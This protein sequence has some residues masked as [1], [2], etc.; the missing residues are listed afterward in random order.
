MATHDPAIMSRAMRVIIH[1]DRP[2]LHVC[3]ISVFGKVVL[4]RNGYSITKKRMWL[5]RHPKTIVQHI[6][7]PLF[8]IFFVILNSISAI[9]EKTDRIYANTDHLASVFLP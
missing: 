5:S 8:N 1:V 2:G 4:Q 3:L 6:K 7:M 9:S